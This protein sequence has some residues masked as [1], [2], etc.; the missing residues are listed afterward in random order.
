MRNLKFLVIEGNTAEVRET[1]KTH[2]NYDPGVDFGHTLQKL[3]PNSEF[4]VCYG[5]DLN[6]KTPT[7]EEIRHYDGAVIGGSALNAPKGEPESERQITIAREIY[8]AGIPFYGSCWGLQMASLAAG[9]KVETAKG[10]REVGQAHAVRRLKSDHPLLDGKRDVYYAIAVHS[11]EVTALP[12]DADLLAENDH[13]P[14]Q[15]L[16]IRHEEGVF[17]GVQ[18]HPEY[19]LNHLSGILR[20]IG[21]QLIA[22]G[23]FRNEEDL[24]SYATDLATLY[25][26]PSR[27]D[28]AW[29]YGISRDV[30]N[31]DFRTRELSNWIE[32][33][34]RPAA[35]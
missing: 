32:H 34:V 29:R 33:A 14:V 13:T 23:F 11:D 2:F 30:I 27:R 6:H 7:Y 9:G 20:R 35:H 24:D 21:D 17:W 28:L 16:E 10:G 15:A 26:D 25:Q 19:S 22:E 8:R 1:V 18:Y 31:D 4:D 12:P 5:A 3:A